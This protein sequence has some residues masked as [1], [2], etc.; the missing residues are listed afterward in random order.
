M[1]HSFVSKHQLVYFP[2]SLAHVLFS[3]SHCIYNT[4][5]LESFFCPLFKPA[6]SFLFSNKSSLRFLNY[7]LLFIYM[8]SLVITR[9][10]TLFFFYPSH[11]CELL[12]ARIYLASL[13]ITRM[14][15]VNPDHFIDELITCI[16]RTISKYLSCC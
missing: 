4:Q 14:S 12:Y 8:A 15:F 2:I 10:R 11:T 6:F 3:S 9:V 16:V 7:M 13:A 1:T 5:E